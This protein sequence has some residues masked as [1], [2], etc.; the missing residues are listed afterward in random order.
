M[1]ALIKQFIEMS[2]SSLIPTKSNLNNSLSSI[3]PK[4]EKMTIRIDENIL[5]DVPA[6]A[7]IL[8]YNEFT[9][10]K[11]LRQKKFKGRKLG[12]KWLVPGSS[13]KAYFEEEN[14]KTIEP[15]IDKKS[16]K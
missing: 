4:G 10:R 2:T 11:L 6:L 5:Y 7:S 15:V 14:E 12:R 13:I 1:E 9:V 8:G 3:L 16:K